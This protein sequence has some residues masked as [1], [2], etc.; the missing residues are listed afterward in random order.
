[1][2]RGDYQVVASSCILKSHYSHLGCHP[3]WSGSNEKQ[4]LGQEVWHQYHIAAVWYWLY[5][6][7]PSQNEVREDEEDCSESKETAALQQSHHK[8]AAY[9]NSVYDHASSYYA[10]WGKRRD[11]EDAGC[12]KSCHAE[13]YHRKIAFGFHAEFSVALDF[14]QVSFYKIYHVYDMGCSEGSHLPD[15]LPAR[16]HIISNNGE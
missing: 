16:A 14:L 13:A 6:H 7:V 5:K 12:K 9:H 8:H 4:P 11:F 10:C 3:I 2:K 1:M 15:E